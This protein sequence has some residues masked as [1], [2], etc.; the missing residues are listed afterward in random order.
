MFCE[1]G[2]PNAVHSFIKSVQAKNYPIEIP[3]QFIQL[4]KELNIPKKTPNFMKYFKSKKKDVFANRDGA[5]LTSEVYESIEDSLI[6]LYKLHNHLECVC[7]K[8]LSTLKKQVS[9][10]ILE[11]SDICWPFLCGFNLT[12][13]DL[14]LLSMLL[15]CLAWVRFLLLFY[16]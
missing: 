2:F 10:D 8:D 13:V 6:N 15:E 3:L 11:K 4:E 1:Q 5:S 12:V 14:L 9:S 16:T 7:E